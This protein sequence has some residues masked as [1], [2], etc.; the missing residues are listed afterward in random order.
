MLGAGPSGLA[1]AKALGER[2]IP[3]AQVESTDH[4]GGNWAHGV[5]ST[6]HIISSRRIIEY[7]DHPMPSDWPDFPSADQMRR[8][9]E[10]YTDSYDLR[11]HIRFDTEVSSVVPLP[12][13]SWQV[14]MRDGTG[15]VFKGVAV[16]NGHHWDKVLPPW[17][18]A[19]AGE[20]IHSKD[21]K[22]PDQLR[23]KRVL[24]LG[25]GNSG[26]DIVS[27]AARVGAAHWSLRRGYCGSCRRRCSVA[28][29]WS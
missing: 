24:V 21:Y 25:G 3:Y 16:C 7:T 27:E 2:G 4:V 23:G 29:R 5:Y 17:A 20:L 13:G 28:Q 15:E 9:Y 19:F 10:D 14:T 12:D 22:H 1:V 11:R 26:C 18:A 6:A 8:Y